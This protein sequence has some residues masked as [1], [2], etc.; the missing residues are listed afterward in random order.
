MYL[1][2]I[3]RPK[4]IFIPHTNDIYVSGYMV[5]KHG[6]IWEPVEKTASPIQSGVKKIPG[7]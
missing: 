1:P 3:Q 5:T 4:V 6:M 2:K 7:S